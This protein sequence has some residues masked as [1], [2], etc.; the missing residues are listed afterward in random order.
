MPAGT[1][2]LGG[3]CN[4]TNRQADDTMFKRRNPS[5]GESWY[6]MHPPLYLPEEGTYLHAMTNVPAAETRSL[7]TAVRGLGKSMG[8]GGG[9]QISQRPG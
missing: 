5:T 4:A 2:A 6:S 3:Q 9:G 8:G 1:P 7:T